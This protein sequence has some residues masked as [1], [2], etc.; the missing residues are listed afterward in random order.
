[1]RACTAGRTD[2]PGILGFLREQAVF[3]ASPAARRD[4]IEAILANWPWEDTPK[5]ATFVLDRLA[6]D[7]ASVRIAM[8]SA[9]AQDWSG[10][11]H[12]RG[13]AVLNLAATDVDYAVRVKMTEALSVSDGVPAAR[14]AAIGA[15]AAGGFTDT[16]VRTFVKSAHVPRPR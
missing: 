4:A 3:D 13:Q 5:L 9:I 2:D 10:T 12:A 1:M 16:D 8:V 6:N 14:A 7:R 15:L 11:T